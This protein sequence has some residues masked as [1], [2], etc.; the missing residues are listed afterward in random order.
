MVLAVRDGSFLSAG[1]CGVN[2]AS[3]RPARH[4]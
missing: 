1:S 2:L 3:V 4:L